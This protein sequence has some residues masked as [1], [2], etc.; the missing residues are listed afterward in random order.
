MK[1]RVKSFTK[2]TSNY[3]VL[4]NKFLGYIHKPEDVRATIRLIK[5]DR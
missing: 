2:S 3:A 1:I 5:N 4:T